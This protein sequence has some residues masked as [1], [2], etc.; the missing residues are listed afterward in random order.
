MTVPGH[1]ML[2]NFLNAAHYLYLPTN[3]LNALHVPGVYGKLS[4]L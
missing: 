4:K 3:K 2:I 1:S